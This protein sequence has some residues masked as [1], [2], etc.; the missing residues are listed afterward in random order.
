MNLSQA[1]GKASL[2]AV[3]SWKYRIAQASKPRKK[4]TSRMRRM[5]RVGR[6]IGTK[7]MTVQI[8]PIDDDAGRRDRPVGETHEA[9]VAEDDAHG[10]EQDREGRLRDPGDQRAGH[11]GAEDHQGPGGGESQRARSASGWP[12]YSR[13]PSA[14]WS[15]RSPSRCRRGTGRRTSR[16]SA[17]R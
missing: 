7:V 17:R 1:A 3:P 2:A 9:R 8:G 15:R 14:A 10:A 16:R 12:A 5:V 4:P 13:P 11:H 6:I